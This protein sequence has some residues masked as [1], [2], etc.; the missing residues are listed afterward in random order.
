MR[1]CRQRHRQN[2]HH[3]CPRSAGPLTQP[4]VVASAATQLLHAFG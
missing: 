2:P 4:C 3:R 1:S